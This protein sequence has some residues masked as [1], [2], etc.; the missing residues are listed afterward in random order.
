[1]A[2]KK[3]RD[4]IQTLPED[5]LTFGTNDDDLLRLEQSAGWLIGGG[6]RDVLLGAFDNDVILGDA[7]WTLSPQERR[8]ERRRDLADFA[9]TL[10][11]GAGSDHVKGGRGDDTLRYTM[12]ENVGERDFYVGGTGND[13]LHLAFSLEEWERDDVQ[14]DI[15]AY[16]D[17]LQSRIDEETGQAGRGTFKFSAF[18]LKAQ[19]FEALKVTVDGIEVDPSLPLFIAKD[20]LFTIA[21]D[22]SATPFT[23][24]LANDRL[25]SSVASITLLS[26]PSHGALSFSAAQD[27][28]PDGSFTFEPGESFDNL[29]AGQ[30]RDVKFAYEVVSTDGSKDQAQVTL[31]VTGVNDTPT[32][33]AGALTAV[34]DGGTVTIDLSSLGNDTDSDDD[35]NS[36]T[37]G[38]ET[39]PIEGTV[40]LVGSVLTFDPGDDFQSLNVG[41]TKEV[42]AQISATDRHGAT[43]VNDI[44]VTITGVNDRPVFVEQ[45]VA[46]NEGET[47]RL[48]LTKF[49]SDPDSEDDSGSL[50]YRAPVPIP[51]GVTVSNGQL[52]YVTAGL[53]DD[54]QEGETE[55]IT[56]APRLIDSR[57][58]TAG[59]NV[60]VTIHGVNDAPV[61]EALDLGALLESDGSTTFDLAALATVTDPDNNTFT[62]SNIR[63]TDE[64]GASVS[65][66]DQGD[67]VFAIFPGNFDDLEDG[68]RTTLTISYDVSDGIATTTGTAKLDIIG[69]SITFSMFGLTLSGLTAGG[70][71]WSVSGGDFNGDGFDDVIVGDAGASPAGGTNVGETHLIFGRAEE[72]F[73]SP[74]LS[75]GTDS[76]KF[77]GTADY[78]NSGNSIS[79]AGDVN[80]DGIDDI[81][82][83]AFSANANAGR[84][85]VVFGSEHAFA[86]SSFDLSSLNGSNGFA[87]NGFPTPGLGTPSFAGFS[88]SGAGDVNGDG[89]D[90]L[91]VASVPTISNPNSGVAGEPDVITIGATYVVFGQ[92]S[93]FSSTFELNSINGTNGFSVVSESSNLAASNVSS[94]GDINGDGFDDIIIGANNASPDGKSDAGATYVVFGKAGGFD[95]VLG[96]ESLNGSNGFVLTGVNAND[97]SGFSVSE[98]GDV[99]GDGLDD[100]IIGANSAT[101]NGDE[102]AGQT[103]V[104]FGSTSDFGATLDLSALDGTNGFVLNGRSEGDLSGYSVASAG[105]V[106]GDGFDD[107]LIG[108]VAADP[109]NNI[110]FKFPQSPP[111]TNAGQTYLVYGKETFG[112]SFSLNALDGSNGYAFNGTTILDDSGYSV[113]GVGDVNDDGFDDIII[114]AG[115]NSGGSFILNEEGEY[116]FV[117]SPI[118]VRDEGKA[119]VIFGGQDRL[120]ALERVFIPGTEFQ[121][122]FGDGQLLLSNLAADPDLS[123]F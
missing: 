101:A 53:Y 76:F 10:D 70:I 30:T 39:D 46:I 69:E 14:S 85:Y 105:D 42:I 113:A 79:N 65:V 31:R 123:I 119:Y 111:V 18:G 83:G 32:L 44:T 74:N 35:G 13:T 120:D 38:I 60:E 92:T 96:V 102:S 75:L 9:D 48:D 112:A 5:Q 4:A 54:L 52:T 115:R 68:E 87:L 43:T 77:V 67:G 2:R 49:A 3:L 20:D 41:E 109:E 108:A 84:A 8:L 7:L 27:G 99:N 95:A 63:A 88:V 72:D 17:F 50:L 118:G 40:S 89:V 21:E 73:A 91:L 121:D 58:A 80:G 1:M 61:V 24:V 106:N 57:Y 86:G 100:I 81:I 78:D 6:G 19:K 26:Q 90:D 15:A 97:M 28:T 23:S 122:G 98:A 22:A 103:Y 93:G 71:G 25:L 29:A 64:D 11:G 116:E 62:F 56:L 45:N 114:S 36:L 107:L 110:V 12:S 59:A 33:A 16:L 117:V 55:T 37:Y 82:I 47:L 66:G 51:D 94:A 34:E 104:V